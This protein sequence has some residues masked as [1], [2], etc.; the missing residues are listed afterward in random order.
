MINHIIIAEKGNAAHS[1]FTDFKLCHNLLKSEYNNITERENI[2][3]IKV[4]STL[5]H[6]FHK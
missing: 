6:W 5:V 4:Q 3:R 1:H 2:L